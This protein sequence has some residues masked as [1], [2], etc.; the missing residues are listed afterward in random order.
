[1]SDEIRIKIS[2]IKSE[3]IKDAARLADALGTTD[4]DIDTK[5][6]AELAKYLSGDLKKEENQ[7][8]L[9]KESDDVKAIFGL[10]VTSPIERKE[11]EAAKAEK[12]AETKSEQKDILKELK[13]RFHKIMEY[14]EETNTSNGITAKEAYKKVKEECKDKGKE[15]QKA[16][17]E[18]KKYA[19][20]DFGR[21]RNQRT[22]AKIQA[23]DKDLNLVNEANLEYD[24]SRKVYRRIKELSIAENNGVEDK[25][26]K[27]TI[28]DN[29]VNIFKKA[30]RFISGTDSEGKKDDKGIAAGNTA[31][32]IREKESF[33][34]EQLL[35]ALGKN[36]PLLREYTDKK[37]N[38]HENILVAAKLITKDGNE[39][40]VKGLSKIVG[41]SIGI[42]NT[43]NDHDEHNPSEIQS[44][45][46]N[47]WNAMDDKEFGDF[48]TFELKDSQIRNLVDFLGYHDD[49]SKLLAVRIWQNLMKGAAAGAA[50]G[51]ASAATNIHTTKVHVDAKQ[52]VI[53][54][55]EGV[56]E[57][58]KADFLKGLKTD[59]SLK[60]VAA[61]ADYGNGY[62]TSKL[63]ELQE[64]STGIRL[65]QQVIAD[66]KVRRA[67]REI[68]MG[69]MT[70]AGM[71]A[72]MGVLD[73][74]GSHAREKDVIGMIFDC[75]TTYEK[76]IGKIDHAYSDKNLSP[77]MK[78]A[79]KKIAEL[80]IVKV[81]DPETGIMKAVLNDDCTVQWSL[82]TFMKAYNK[83]RGNIIFN[84]AEI[85]A[86]AR[87]VDAEKY[88]IP[89]CEPEKKEEPKNS[90]DITTR[91]DINFKDS[92]KYGWHEIIQMYYSDCLA[93]HTEKEIRYAL[94]KANNIPNTL[95]YVP[96]NLLL[97]Y[98][99]FEGEDECTRTQQK[100]VKK[101]HYNQKLVKTTTKTPNGQ[102]Q[103]GIVCTD[104]NGNKTTTWLPGKHNSKAEAEA[105]ASKVI[106]EESN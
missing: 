86:A 105:A 49:R 102:W 14:N 24:K 89:E 82:C 74:L 73:T 101:G 91:S 93:S 75:D 79:L 65:T 72:A 28:R 76:I 88:E 23:Y 32:R 92:N 43:L 15:Y 16:V 95:T 29:D 37:G 60:N 66:I 10:K 11:P 44:I 35:K 45:L 30:G 97:P 21:I 50:I 61:D 40:R 71:G 54:D 106:A 78:E 27:R 12:T 57:A 31:T 63:S 83:A 4:G 81:P 67:L 5:E 98:Q 9:A 17:D 68:L 64:T 69:T 52:N 104:K 80:G 41:T 22:R 77:E 99:L 25:W 103:G 6:G 53:I 62:I 38:K 84:A 56:T 3:F 18:L 51:A 13:D 1:M 58:Q 8:K 100:E 85:R 36:N 47:L 39:Y 19:K 2:S 96:A 90:C 26:V 59:S 70:G 94:R 87:T 20:H 48:N 7:K 33:T 42:D 55:F 46:T 34:K